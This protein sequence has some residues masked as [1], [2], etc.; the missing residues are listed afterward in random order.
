VNVCDGDAAAD[1][2]AD[3]AGAIEVRNLLAGRY[4]VS[5]SILPVEG[6]AA[7]FM[8][9]NPI[10][11]EVAPGGSSAAPTNS[12]G[13]VF[14]PATGDV[15][16]VALSEDGATQI[17]LPELTAQVLCVWLKAEDGTTQQVCD[18]DAAD[19]DPTPGKI[20]AQDLAPG[21]YIVT[22]E[23][24]EQVSGTPTAGGDFT[25][26]P[27]DPITIVI[28]PAKTA[29]SPPVDAGLIFTEAEE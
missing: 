27:P 15:G 26:E 22:T 1:G 3:A 17:E 5:T 16:F 14:A 12:A 2:K 24:A 11:I 21:R 9:P 10:T 6:T 20:T 18:D 29:G 8:A 4:V 13:L 28:D 19:G 25:L 7:T 23:L